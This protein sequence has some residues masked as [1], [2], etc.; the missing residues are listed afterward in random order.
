MQTLKTNVLIIGAGGAGLRCA[1]EL[2]QNGLEDVLVVG[3]RKFDDAHTTLAAGGI[4]AAMGSLDPED[5]SMIHT[6]DTY[7]EGANIAD[8]AKVHLL[9]KQ[10]VDAI[11]DLHHYGAKFHRESDGK[12]TQRFFGAHTY[13]R[14]VFHGDQ[15]G[16][17]IMRVLVHKANQLEVPHLEDTYI[18]KL[19]EKNGRV[20]GAIGVSNNQFVK[21]EARITVLATG[22]FSNIYARSS[23]RNKENFGEG[24]FLAH[25]AGAKV[26]D[27]ELVQFHPTGMVEPK[28]HEGWLVTEAVRGEGGIL[29]NVKGERFMKN[30]SPEKMELSTRDIV[31]R[32]IFM[33]IK[34]GNGTDKGAV[35]LDI[36]KRPKK[37]I[38]EKLPN[39]YKMFKELQ[40]LDISLKP[41][42]VAP[43]AHYT[44]GGVDFDSKTLK[45]NIKNL[46]AIG[47]CTMGVHGGNRLGGNSL[48]EILVFGKQLGKLI[49]NSS[50]PKRYANKEQIDNNL[51]ST[52]GTAVSTK[53]L[54]YIRKKMWEKVGIIR[55]EKDMQYMLNKLQFITEKVEKQGVVPSKNLT[56]SIINQTRLKST[57][58]LAEL[59]TIGAIERKESRA[60]HYRN[61]YLEQEKKYKGS[62]IFT[63]DEI[64]FRKAK[65]PGPK[66]AHAL[67]EFNPTTNYV[68]LE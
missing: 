19:L 45:T 42:Q 66:L 43:T 8:P 7:L 54:A 29:R 47:E 21:I 32:A 11:F 27:M 23:S 44:M 31:A 49:A 30:Y 13:R 36:S 58:K 24:V 15:T 34:K 6:L 51:L 60:A 28:S 2:F 55:N 1:I 50:M 40:D 9:C 26:G 68:H 10:A 48:A 17:E 38:L 53:E 12:I 3:D 20:Q 61:D 46:Y 57:L 59:I 56:T 65:R 14:T 64:K 22:G 33:E 25:Q 35:F 52:G 18:F 4:N 62:F 67:K 39:M 5:S 16:A 63:N 37:Y 41:M